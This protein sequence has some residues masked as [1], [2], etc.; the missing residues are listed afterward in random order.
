M[1]GRQKRLSANSPANLTSALPPSI[2]YAFASYS[3]ISL[4]THLNKAKTFRESGARSMQSTAEHRR[5]SV[6]N[7]DT[8]EATSH[9]N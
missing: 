9:F 7:I 2:R 3:L 8:T 5:P 6:A 4:S 1:A